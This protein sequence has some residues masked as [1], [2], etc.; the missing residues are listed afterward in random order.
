MHGL[1]S[2]LLAVESKKCKLWSCHPHWE[3]WQ[4]LTM[5]TRTPHWELISYQGQVSVQA[6]EPVSEGGILRRHAL[7]PPGKGCLSLGIKQKNDWDFSVKRQRG[8]FKLIT[9][10][11]KSKIC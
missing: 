2:A 3:V 8:F 5:G 9:L 7:C 10:I 11:L 1:A 6:G 4:I